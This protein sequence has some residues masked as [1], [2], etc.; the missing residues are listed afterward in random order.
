MHVAKLFYTAFLRFRQRRVRAVA[1]GA[2]NEQDMTDLLNG[3]RRGSPTGQ[4][5]RRQRPGCLI[6]FQLA[7]PGDKSPP[8]F[9]EST[10]KLNHEHIEP[11]GHP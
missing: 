2:G 10:L 6:G 9:R 4:P 5:V 7:R 8:K 11:F 1:V 3:N